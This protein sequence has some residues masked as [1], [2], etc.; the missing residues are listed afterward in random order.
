LLEC[1]G[2]I[3][4]GQDDFPERDVAD[5]AIDLVP[6]GNGPLLPHLARVEHDG[7]EGQVGPPHRLSGCRPNLDS[8]SC[9]PITQSRRLTQIRLS[10]SRPVG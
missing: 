7:R 2:G 3:L 1:G 10:R 6:D 4:L 5:E 8:F 9:A